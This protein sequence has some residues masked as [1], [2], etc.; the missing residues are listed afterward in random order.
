MAQ[1]VLV[2]LT[3]DLDGSDADETIMFAL[4]GTSYEIDLNAKNAAALRKALDRYRGSARTT[5]AGRASSAGR[6]GRG[7]SKSRGRGDADSRVVRAWAVENGIPVSSRGRIASD[8]LE[9]FKA[10]SAR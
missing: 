6:R 9:Q 5:K 2:T 3:D 10:Q 4:D 8:V 7:A 1:Q